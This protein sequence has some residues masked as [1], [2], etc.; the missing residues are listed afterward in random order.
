MVA[1]LMGLAL[2]V[3]GCIDVNVARHYPVSRNDSGRMT[4]NVNRP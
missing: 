3:G 4:I 1:C 2:L